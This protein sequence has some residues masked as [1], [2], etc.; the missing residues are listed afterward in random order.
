[1]KTAI[2]TEREKEKDRKKKK[3]ERESTLIKNTSAAALGSFNTALEK[4]KT[5]SS[6]GTCSFEAVE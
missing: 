5:T 1:M 2:D 4:T 6:V 3:R